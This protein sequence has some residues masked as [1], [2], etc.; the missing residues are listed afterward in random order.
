M[1]QIEGRWRTFQAAAAMDQFLRVKDNGSDKLE[2]A[3]ATDIRYLGTLTRAV[4]A[5]DDH[6]AVALRNL[7]GTTPMVASGSI[8]RGAPVYAAASGK[9]ASSGTVLLGEAMEA[10]TANN[11][12]IEVLPVFGEIARG[13]ITQQDAVVYPIPLE[14]IKLWNDRAV[15][16]PAAATADEMGIVTGT[17][18]TDAPVLKGIDSGA[19]TGTSKCGVTF[20]VPAEYVAGETITLR[21]N[22]EMQVVSDG[23]ATLDAQVARQADKTTDICAT[24]LQSINSATPADVDFV[25]T[26]T[27]VVPGDQLDIVLIFAVTDSG[28][29]DDFIN[30]VINTIEFLLD[31]K[32]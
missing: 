17:F 2:L 28:N 13:Q 25:I 24:S 6:V 4:L 30:G 7:E 9:I 21:I 16:L 1:S 11:D 29:A 20:P 8:S 10:A 27:N 23:T 22:A 19:T 12:V 15:N 26:P 5:S 3:G 31:I 32:G 14:R 18:L